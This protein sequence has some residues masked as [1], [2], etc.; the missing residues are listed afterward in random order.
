MVRASRRLAPHHEGLPLRQPQLA[1]AIRSDFVAAGADELMPDR[2]V[3]SAE[4]MLADAEHYAQVRAA[5]YGILD[6][7]NAVKL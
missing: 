1:I 2:Y 3:Q 6:R 7:L 5:M 4:A